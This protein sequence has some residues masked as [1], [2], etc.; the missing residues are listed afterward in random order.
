MVLASPSLVTR[1]YGAAWSIARSIRRC[2]SVATRDAS[3][4]FSPHSRPAERPIWIL[5][6]ARS[7]LPAICM[8]DEILDKRPID[9]PLRPRAPHVTTA[10]DLDP[11]FEKLGEAAI[12]FQ[13][14]HEFVDR[15]SSRARRDDAAGLHR[16]YEARSAQDRQV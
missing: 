8:A 7:R 2:P 13:E 14:P 12:V 4:D 9:R 3:T 5:G 11:A 6:T 10:L 15:L 16:F 1:D